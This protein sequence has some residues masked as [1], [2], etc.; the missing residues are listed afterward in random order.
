MYILYAFRYKHV[1]C[2]CAF[3][4][5]YTRDCA[6]IHKYIQDLPTAFSNIIGR[7]CLTIFGQLWTGM[8]QKCS[9]QNVDFTF[10]YSAVVIV[11]AKNIVYWQINILFY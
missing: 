8:F 3:Y 9:V 11:A 4:I 6:D 10:K 5:Y 7:T 1:C 2:V